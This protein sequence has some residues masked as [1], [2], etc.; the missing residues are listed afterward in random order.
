M[1]SRNLKLIL[2]IS[3]MIPVYTRWRNMNIMFSAN[4]NAT[5]LQWSRGV[6]AGTLRSLKGKLRRF[7]SLEDLRVPDEIL[8]LKWRGIPFHNNI[9]DLGVTYYTRMTW[10]HHIERTVVKAL[11][12]YIRDYFLFKSGCL[13]RNIKLTLYKGL[14]RSVVI[15][16][17]ATWGYAADTNLWKLQRLQN[18]VLPA[19]GNL[20]R[21]KPVHELHVIYEIP[22]M[23]DYITKLCRTQVEVIL[24]PCKWKCTWYWSGLRPSS[25]LTAFSE[26]LNKFRHNLLHKLQW[27]ESFAY[28]V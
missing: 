5:S 12:T 11:R 1:P 3:R 14:I 10:R 2:F 16:A 8:Q 6:S 22:C 23:C 9:T 28:L 21:C 24:K 26:W 4:N 20:E 17:Y 15:Y 13:N 7:I 27:Q 18:R 19:T 25:W